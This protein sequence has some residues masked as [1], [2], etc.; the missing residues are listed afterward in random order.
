[1]SKEI[2]KKKGVLGAQNFEKVKKNCDVLRDPMFVGM[3]P[4]YNGFAI[5]VLDK[6]ANII[7]QKLF[8]S[9]TKKETEDRLLELEKEYKF[10][11][12]IVCLHSVFIE[13]PSYG[14]NGAFVLQMGALH[15]LIRIMLKKAEV[16]YKII[17]PGTLKKFVTGD[18]RAK[19]DLMLL[20][21]YKKWGMEFNDDNLA[22]AYS[23]ARLA[24]EEYKNIA[25]GK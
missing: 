17:S 23:L 25:S 24:L 9:S 19:K 5:V 11:P 16:N 21:V 13:G 3:D 20:N 6:D 22:D 14:S 10:I 18:G 8:G 4:S 7:E 1:M 2:D 12:N 15:F